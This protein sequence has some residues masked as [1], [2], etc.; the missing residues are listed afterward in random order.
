MARRLAGGGAS[1]TLAGA[2]D[3][4]DLLAAYRMA[5]RTGPTSSR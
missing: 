3:D 2:L 5:T 4:A 1:I